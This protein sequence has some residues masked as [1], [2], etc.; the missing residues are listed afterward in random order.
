MGRIKKSEGSRAKVSSFSADPLTLS[1]LADLEQM[2]RHKKSK[3]IGDA[4]KFYHESVI[5]PPEEDK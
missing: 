2:L 1:L 5:H 3:I 4:I